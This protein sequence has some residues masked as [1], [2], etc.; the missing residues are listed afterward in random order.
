MGTAPSP[1][2]GDGS[3]R[4]GPGPWRWGRARRGHRRHALSDE[5]L[6]DQPI[7]LCGRLLDTLSPGFARWDYDAP[8]SCQDCRE[9]RDEL[10]GVADPAGRAHRRAL[11]RLRRGLRRRRL[12]RARARAGPRADGPPRAGPPGR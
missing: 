8:D 4:D 6:G 1:N 3:G 5:H 10:A 12:R 9:V 2:P 11:A 7:A